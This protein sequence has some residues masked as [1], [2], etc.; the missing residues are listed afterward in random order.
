MNKL[1]KIWVLVIAVAV[2]GGCRT[3]Q[4]RL[5]RLIQQHPELIKA[6]DTVTVTDTIA[7]YTHDTIIAIQQLKDTVTIVKEHTTVKLFSVG[8]DSLGVQLKQDTI[9]KEVKVPVPVVQVEKQTP[10]KIYVLFGG[11]VLLFA[12]LLYYLK[13]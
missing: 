2:I 4:Q 3:P 9:F 12:L 11:L 10:L 1:L 8:S 5:N 13:K 6:V 7:G